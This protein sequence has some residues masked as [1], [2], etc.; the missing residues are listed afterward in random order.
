MKRN[1]E[2]QRVI[3]IFAGMDI[4]RKIGFCGRKT[5]PFS[6][7]SSPPLPSSSAQGKGKQRTI[8]PSRV[9][10]WAE[11]EEEGGGGGGGG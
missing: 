8:L 1:F 6:S 7:S 10:P 2:S 4:R 5:L 11:E 3:I 9:D